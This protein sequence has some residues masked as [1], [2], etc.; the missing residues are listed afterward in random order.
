MNWNKFAPK[1]IQ[2]L[3][4]NTGRESKIFRPLILKNRRINIY[5]TCNC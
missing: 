2:Y 1:T 3:G 5:E 4:Q